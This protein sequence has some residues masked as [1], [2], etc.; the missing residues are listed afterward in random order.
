MTCTTNSIAPLI[1]GDTRKIEI[2]ITDEFGVPV[3]IQGHTIFF[4]LKTDKT[5]ADSLATLQVSYTVATDADA[6]VGKTVLVLSATDTASVPPG[7]Y[8][9]DIQWV[10]TGATPEVTTI[11]LGIVSVEYDITVDVV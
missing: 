5:L 1:R 8:F 6:L 2:T 11:A 7:K 3:N 4:T 10:T 9:Y